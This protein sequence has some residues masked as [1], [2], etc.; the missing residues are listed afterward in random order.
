MWTADLPVRRQ[1]ISASSHGEI[2]MF[3]SFSF[4]AVSLI[5]SPPLWIE[6]LYYF[7]LRFH[8][9]NLKDGP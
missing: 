1:D 5:F 7:T 9:W 4:T 2:D 3:R 8:Y 6:G